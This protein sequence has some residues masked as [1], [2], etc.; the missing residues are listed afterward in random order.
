M[1]IAEAVQRI[2]TL[3]DGELTHQVE[4]NLSYAPALSLNDLKINWERQ[5]AREIEQLVNAANPDYGGAAT[6]L[7][8]QTIR[9]LEVSRAEL[10]GAG[11][12]LPGT[13]VYADLNHGIFVGCN[14]SEYLRI[15]VTQSSEGILSGF[16]LASLGV[17]AGERLET[18]A[19]Q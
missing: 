17:S 18:I 1:V 4:D 15:N 19:D 9:I 14:N 11:G 6:V 10:N 8:G 12:H 5:S 7:R 2:N 13:I 16:K 3:R